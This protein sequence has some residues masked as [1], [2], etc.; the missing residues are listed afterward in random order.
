MS[1][2]SF[3]GVPFDDIYRGNDAWHLNH[4]PPIVNKRDHIVLY[5]LPIEPNSTQPPKPYPGEH[6]WDSHH[7]RLPCALQNEYRTESSV[8]Q[9]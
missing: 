4:L 8:K 3:K 2:D 6:K 5:Q 7:V 1:T 9:I